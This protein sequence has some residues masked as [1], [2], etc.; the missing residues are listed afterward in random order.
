MLAKKVLKWN[1]RKFDE[2]DVMK[3]KHPHLKAFRA[4]AIEGYI[5]AMILAPVA[6]LTGYIIGKM[7]G[8]MIKK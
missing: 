6:Y 3:D 8:K 1:D 2:I 7:I 5:D 4:G